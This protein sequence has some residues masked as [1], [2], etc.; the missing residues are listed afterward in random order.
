MLVLRVGVLDLRAIGD[1]PIIS[2][3]STSVG[4]GIT[5]AQCRDRASMGC[6]AEAKN[7]EVL[8]V[9]LIMSHSEIH[10][11]CGEGYLVGRGRITVAQVDLVETWR[12]NRHHILTQNFSKVLRWHTR[13]VNRTLQEPIVN[14][15][16]A[17]VYENIVV[18]TKRQRAVQIE[19]NVAI[20]I[21]E[22][23]AFR[24]LE[25]QEAQSLFHNI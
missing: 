25:V 6:T 5:A 19:D 18:V 15:A 21:L 10:D 12:R 14:V 7:A 2:W 8:V 24:L 3:R 23:V 16:I 22:E 17:S 11:G 20:C 13:N 1:R 4:S 9:A